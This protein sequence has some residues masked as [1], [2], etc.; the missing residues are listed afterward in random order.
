VG[1][2][3]GLLRRLVLGQ[4]PFGD[5]ADRSQHQPALDR[6]QRQLDRHLHAVASQ[7][8]QFTAGGTPLQQG[9]RSSRLPELRPVR[10][11]GNESVQWQAE[12][13]FV[14]ITKQ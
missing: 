9:L 14:R 5:V 2:F 10:P 6:V 12:Q 3:V 1:K 7:G 4:P 8:A 11:I 13:L